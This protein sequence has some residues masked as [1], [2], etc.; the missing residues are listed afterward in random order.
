LAIILVVSGLTGPAMPALGAGEGSPEGAPAVS[1]PAFV[2]LPLFNI[3]VIEG[4]K[5]TRQI[6][7]GVAL[8]LVEG[9]K[10]DSIGEKQPMLIDAF[11]RDLY[12]MFGQRSGTSRVAIQASIKQRLTQTAEKVLGPGIVRQVLVL[13]LLERQRPQ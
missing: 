13:E 6:T 7:V 11:F 1:G 3:P 5:V 2:K 12:S 4:D 8:E 10:P 9:L